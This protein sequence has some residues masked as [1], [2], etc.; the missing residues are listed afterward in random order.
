MF[1]VMLIVPGWKCFKL[2]SVENDHAPYLLI[3]LTYPRGCILKPSSKRVK[4]EEKDE[5][6]GKQNQQ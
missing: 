3:N 1:N 5:K 6:N 4:D 2:F